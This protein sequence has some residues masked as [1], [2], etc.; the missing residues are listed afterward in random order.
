MNPSIKLATIPYNNSPATSKGKYLY[1]NAGFLCMYLCVRSKIQVS[2]TRIKSVIW[3]VAQTAQAERV[4]GTR[5]SD[6]GSF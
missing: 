1:K 4:H 3:E 2:Y 6:S 5:Y